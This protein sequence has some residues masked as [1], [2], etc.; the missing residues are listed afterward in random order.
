MKRMCRIED[1]MMMCTYDQKKGELGRTTKI[2]HE[3]A[4]I[5]TPAPESDQ[6]R[7]KSFVS[8]YW[9]VPSGRTS[10]TC[11]PIQEQGCDVS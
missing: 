11:L 10:S 2:E 6:R 1:V 9:E 8:P 7:E 3:V 5:F 4:R